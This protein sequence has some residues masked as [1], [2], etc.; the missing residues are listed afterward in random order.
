MKYTKIIAKIDSMF[1]TRLTKV[2]N[3]QPKC[4]KIF[5]KL[6][7]MLK[8]AELDT[9]SMDSVKK[10]KESINGLQEFYDEF[11]NE[12]N[13]KL[14]NGSVYKHFNYYFNCFNNNKSN[15]E[16]IE[17]LADE[18]IDFAHN[19]DGTFSEFSNSIDNTNYYY[20]ESTIIN[21]LSNSEYN[22][23]LACECEYMDFEKVLKFL[24]KEFNKLFEEN[25]DGNYEY[26]ASI[27]EDILKELKQNIRCGYANNCGVV[28]IG[29]YNL[30]DNI[31]IYIDEQEIN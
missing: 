19:F 14:N 13:F 10:Y 25:D 7:L 24:K 18:A 15:K 16:P 31:G 8:Y 4:V 5:K 20:D 3:N 2:A 26:C 17:V 11:S 28:K 29:N 12:Y 6:P 21:I 23:V 1:N 30:V 22:L 9:S 27:C